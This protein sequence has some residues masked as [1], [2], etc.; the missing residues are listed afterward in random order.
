MM[1]D[2]PQPASKRIPGVERV[3]AHCCSVACTNP[4]RIHTPRRPTETRH[5]LPFGTGFATTELS[6]KL[7]STFPPKWSRLP[8]SL[9]GGG[10]ACLIAKKTDS[11]MEKSETPGYPYPRYYHRTSVD[12]SAECNTSVPLR[13]GGTTSAAVRPWHWWGTRWPPGPARS[14][15]RWS[16]RR[17]RR[18]LPSTYGTRQSRWC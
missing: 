9:R 12:W 11:K 4:T 18:A 15:W 13:P 8:A 14:G 7:I 17:G 6:P 10:G 2:P 5:L 1:A 16:W 3:A